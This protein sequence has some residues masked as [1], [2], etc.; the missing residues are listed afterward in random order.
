VTLGRRFKDFNP[1]N[2]DT[3]AAPS[4]GAMKNGASVQLLDDKNAEPIFNLFR[5]ESQD[6]VDST[7]VV[8][9]NGT[10]TSGTAGSVADELRTIGF[11]VPQTD[12]G[13]ADRFDYSQTVIRYLPGN[14]AKAE[15]LASHLNASP[16]LEKT[17]FIANADLVLVVGSDWQGTRSTP[18]STVPL[19]TSTTSPSD[20][21]PSTSTTIGVV[22]QTPEDVSC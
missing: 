20:A 4:V 10:P 12:V 1:Q 18:G 21:V 13:N 3:Y 7:I 17:N 5:G 11:S 2:L 22:P 8:V 14:E 15:T 19:S 6:A 16:Q 9:Q